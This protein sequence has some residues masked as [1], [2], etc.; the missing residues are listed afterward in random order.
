VGRKRKDVGR[1]DKIRTE[2]GDGKEEVDN[3]M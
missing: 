2:T 3:K 1:R